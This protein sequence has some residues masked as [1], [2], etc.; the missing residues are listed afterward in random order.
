MEGV[1]RQL[2]ISGGITGDQIRDERRSWTGFCIRVNKGRAELNVF[3]AH[4]CPCG[5]QKS[6]LTFRASLGT[7]IFEKHIR[8]VAIVMSCELRLPGLGSVT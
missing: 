5:D 7:G 8:C 6:N 2:N 3:K 1:N 4:P